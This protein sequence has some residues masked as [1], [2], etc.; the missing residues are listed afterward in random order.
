MMHFWSLHPGG[1]HFLLADGSVRIVAYG[2]SQDVLK[3][4]ATANGD[5]AI[6]MP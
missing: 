3:A 2:V 6:Q 1:S 5:E 4:I